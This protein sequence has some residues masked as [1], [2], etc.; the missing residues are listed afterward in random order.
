MKKR[1]ILLIV[2]ALVIC[3]SFVVSHP[4][5]R[6]GIKRVVI[7]AGH[8]GHDPGT[9]GK[10][11]KEKDVAL[12]VALKLGQLIKD[13]YPD[14]EVIFTRKTDVFIELYRRSQIANE[15]KADL[16]ISIHCNGTKASDAHGVETW[17]M[18]LHKSQANLEVAKKENASILMED[19]YSR[20]DGFDPN[21]PEANIIFSL[22]QNV[23][24]DQSLDMATR[25]QNHFQKN[26]GLLNRGVKQ[27]GF[28]VLYKTT[29]PGILVETG[30]LSNPSD[31]EYLMSDKGQEN[32]ASAIFKAFADYKG[33]KPIASVDNNDNKKLNISQVNESTQK[34]DSNPDPQPETRK[35]TVESKTVTKAGKVS[36]SSPENAVFKVQIIS[37]PRKLKENSPQFKG[38][39]GLFC[40]NQKGTYKYTTGECATLNEALQI[41]TAM[42]QKGFKDAFVVAFYKG[43]RITID[44]AKKINNK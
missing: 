9:M 32:I 22:Y 17:V 2:F 23:Y 5:K 43:D 41:Q 40:Y 19:N 33:E 21:S 37:S 8:G 31:E 11:S 10:R 44:E 25:V 18:G 13:N 7:D 1:F 34:A 24:L 39:K 3:T 35:S 6:S 29:M 15:N 30:F 16:F 38:L 14:V 42:Q 20:Y 27:A 4:Q 26:L 12:A 28:W 36:V